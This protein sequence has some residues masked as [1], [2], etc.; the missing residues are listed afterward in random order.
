MNRQSGSRT[1]ASVSFRVNVLIVVNANL[2]ADLQLQS[3]ALPNPQKIPDKG[4]LPPA[5]YV[6]PSFSKVN[7]TRPC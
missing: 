2:R 3:M 5:T 7:M 6:W 1:F 4:V